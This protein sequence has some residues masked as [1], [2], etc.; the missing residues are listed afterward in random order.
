M[1]KHSTKIT[2]PEQFQAILVV[3]LCRG[4][5]KTSSRREIA[6]FKADWFRIGDI[7]RKTEVN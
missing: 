6:A 3:Y 2:S 4:S 5:S 7:F 1:H